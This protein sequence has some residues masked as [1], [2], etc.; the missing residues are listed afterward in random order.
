MA[1]H[2]TANTVSVSKWCN[3]C[4]RFTPHN[5]SSGRVGHCLETHGPRNDQGA[6]PRPIAQNA[7]QSLFSRRNV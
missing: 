3:R 6:A 7:Q 2:Y 1:H 5:V 4:R